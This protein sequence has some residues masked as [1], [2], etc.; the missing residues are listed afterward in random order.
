MAL[1]YGF[2]GFGEV[3]A[4]FSAALVQHGVRVLATDALMKEKGGE[5]TLRNRMQVDGIQL[6]PLMKLLEESD[7][8]FSSVTTMVARQVAEEAAPSL[9]PGQVYLDLNSTSPGVKLEI[10]AVIAAGSGDFV[11]AAVL[12]AVGATG[13]RT[14]I[15]LC[16]ERGDEVAELLT[17]H[18]LNATFY[19]S[20]IGQASTFKMLRS[21]FSKGLECLVIEFLIAARRAE[22]EDA[23][24]SDI[25]SF[26]ASKPF[27]V[28][29]D[30]WTRSHGTAHERRYHEMLQV[31]ETMREL[32]VEPIMTEATT[33]LFKRSVAM[34][35]A[36]RLES[37]SDLRNA[38]LD[39]L[40]QADR[41]TRRT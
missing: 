17:G 25:T 29:A 1:A 21:I 37:A 7:V 3:A 12:G 38:V 14:R 41:P 16:G 27:D 15:L 5:A 26:M 31:L 19:S 33:A 34:D 11:E 8:V 39:A 18:G 24:W 6:V 4:V 40:E 20:K 28:I 32:G 30:N 36:S 2:I 13:A 22:I 35:L 9:R 10:A 23:L